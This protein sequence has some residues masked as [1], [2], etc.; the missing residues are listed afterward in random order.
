MPEERRPQPESISV[1][2]PLWQFH[3]K[4]LHVIRS[5]GSNSVTKQ[6]NNCI[7]GSAVDSTYHKPKGK[8]FNLSNFY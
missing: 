7:T 4:D 5:G 2:M 3:I 8:G 6:T 1:E